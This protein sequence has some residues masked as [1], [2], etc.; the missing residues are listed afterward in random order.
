MEMDF[1]ITMRSVGLSDLCCRPGVCTHFYALEVKRTRCQLRRSWSLLTGN[2]Q[3][4]NGCTPPAMDRFSVTASTKLLP[5]S[6]DLACHICY[7]VFLV[8]ELQPAAP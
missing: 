3:T 1:G 5:T 2:R 4:Y 8:A 7:L 6:R